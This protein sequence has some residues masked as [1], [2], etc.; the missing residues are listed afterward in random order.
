VKAYQRALQLIPLMFVVGGWLHGAE[1]RTTAR[2]FSGSPNRGAPS[3]PANL[4]A[5]PGN[6]R[7]V[8]RW[9]DSKRAASYTVYRSQSSGGQNAIRI[10]ANIRFTTFTDSN[11]TNGVTY[12]Y[13]VAAVNIFGASPLSNE[14]KATPTGPVAP[15]APANLSAAPGD[16]KVVL[17]WAAS[18]GATSY[19]LYRGTSP[20]GQGTTPM[21]TGITALTVSDT[22]VKNGTRYYYKVAAVNASG[23]S[24]QSNE[25][26]AMPT[27]PV[28]P[29]AP[30]NLSAAPGDQKVVLAWAASAGAA[31]YNLYRGTTAGGQSATPLRT[32][33]TALTVADTGLTNGTR[34]YYKVAA[35]GTGGMSGPS[36]EANAMPTGP[37]AP[38]APS[39]LSAMP[40]DQQVVLAWGASTGASSY[41][42]YRG[43]S[44]GGESATPLRT[45]ITA[46]TVTDTGLT[47]GTRYYYKVAAVSAGGT[48][49]QSNEANAMPAAPGSS[50][51]SAAQKDAFRFLRQSTFGPNMT[52][53][54]HVV[55]VGKPAFLAEQFALPASA[56]PDT[57][58]SLPNME[59]VSEQM[60]QNAV[61][62]QD[63]LRQRV[64]W[65]LSQIFV[66]SAVKVDN[67]HAMVPY[68]RMLQQNA[69]GNVKNIM[70]E[71]SLSPA[72]G[73]F[74]DMV[75][76]KKANPTTGT[77]PN[78][79]YA[80]EWLQLFSI[81]LQ[82]LN[83]NG[84]PMLTNGA[85]TPTFTQSTVA[86]LARALTGWT[87]GDTKAT[88][89]TGLNPRYYDG[90]M[91]PVNNYHDMTQKMV[92]GQMI[93]AGLTARQEFDTV[94]DI[95]FN[96][97]NVG[98]FLVR[99]LIQKLVTS[100]PSPT[101]IGD[102][103]AVFNNNGQGIRGDLQAVVRAILLHPEA[104]NGTA[105][106][107]KFSE[108]A[109]FV[110]TLT[111]ALGATV[112]D[113]PFLT[114]FSQSMSQRIWF[115]PSVF[116]YY[117]PNYRAGSL[118]S[119]E[120]QIWTTAT[121]MTRTN[122][123]ASLLSGGFGSAMVV[124]YT[125][126]SSVASNTNTLVDTV[127]ARI[128]G[129]TMS[130]E[131]KQAILTALSAT[132]ST[133]ERVRTALYLAASAMQ[134]QVEH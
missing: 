75:N 83:D 74:L 77:Q 33:I 45:G 62:G 63:Q 122:F 112:T 41:N 91:K 110:L 55:Q 100:N 15:P 86:D 80:R 1:Y 116:N 129:G 19:N 24:G 18:A 32:G 102:V 96:H 44:A 79:N 11:R 40:G 8:L 14:A 104:V 42:L 114:D 130:P 81:G 9:S 82:E 111:R 107:G 95:V 37:V 38:P 36:N 31:S 93:P 87:Y 119:P 28:A 115:A 97:H 89:P 17:A 113:H 78:E 49:G 99:Q 133:N 66:V 25:A 117:S 53:V 105:T 123:V 47:N 30:A 16:Q 26:S 106:S 6:R 20:G 22:G 84:T 52:L 35:V 2:V 70:R 48:S 126:F 101:Y 131:M 56:Y 109:L 124:D 68:I 127:D 103:V 76:N 118:F 94:L 85:P 132:T 54:D 98:P 90:P 69:F 134:Y 128:M 5:T 88:D 29:P 72:M 61:Q 71:V 43:T 59:L 125:P 13:K 10:A 65:A 21:R 60:M 4:T 121:A 92:L 23:A 39:N 64:A 12:Y 34:Y 73:E 108:P 67:T 120:M 7:V 58:I 50:L 27:G 3:A 46:L 51:L 57:L